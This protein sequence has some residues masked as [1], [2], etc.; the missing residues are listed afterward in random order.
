MKRLVT[1]TA[2]SLVL[3]ALGSF[4]FLQNVSADDTSDLPP[5]AQRLA[6]RFGLNQ[7]EVTTFMEEM[8]EERQA[9][10]QQAMEDRLNQAVED[11]KLTFEQKTELLQKMEDWHANREDFRDL[12]REE[13]QAQ[14]EAH[15]AEMQE[16]AEA[17]GIDLSDILQFG[18]KMYGKGFG[19]GFKKGY[20][21]GQAN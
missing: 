4:A 15:R 6:E 8:H 5:F 21:V 3:V 9:N 2:L 17:N 12:T 11:G 18:G 20:R 1:I 13:R 7:D 16:W 14:H 19:N 10:R